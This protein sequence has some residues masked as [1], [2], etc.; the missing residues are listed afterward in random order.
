MLGMKEPE[1]DPFLG[2]KQDE[3]VEQKAKDMKEDVREK[4]H[5]AS[6]PGG[7][8][9]AQQAKDKA[10]DVKEDA[11]QKMHDAS[12][13]GTAYSQQTKSALHEDKPVDKSLGEKITEKVTDAK[14]AVR[15]KLHEMTSPSGP[16]YVEQA[17][18]KI[19]LTGQPDQGSKATADWANQPGMADPKPLDFPEK[20]ADSSSFSTG[21]S[22]TS[23]FPEQSQGKMFETTATA[24]PSTENP[25]IGERITHMKD[26]VVEKI[27]DW[28]SP[29]PTTASTENQ[30]TT[31]TTPTPAMDE[32]SRRDASALPSQGSD[33]THPT[34]KS[35]DA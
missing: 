17:K 7:P 10:W 19:G 34:K 18:E 27:H 16:T 15:D 30:F 25:T 24:T 1:P 32:A 6:A 8:S 9:Y 29:S 33:L 13:G 20:K 35:I 14:E 2:W 11:K 4:I 5:E 31:T 22:G 3:K 23:S 28:I 26:A 21:A 12:A